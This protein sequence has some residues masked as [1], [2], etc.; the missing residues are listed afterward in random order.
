[1]ETPARREHPQ[2]APLEINRRRGLDLGPVGATAVVAGIAAIAVAAILAVI[3]PDVVERHLLD[4]EA[5]SIHGTVNK[6]ADSL[7][8]SEVSAEVDPDL[9]QT[10]V[11]RF[12][13]GR[14]IVRVKIWDP[15]GTIVFSDEERLIGSTYAMSNDL[16]A[17]F[18]GELISETPDLTRPENRYDTTFGELREY[19]IPV[20]SGPQGIEVV[21]EVYQ[22][23]D[24]LVNT[25]ADIRNAVRAALGIG[26]VMLLAALTAAA[27]AN[28]RAERRRQAR[29]QRLIGQLIEIREDERTRIIGALHDDIGQPLYRILFGLQAARGMVEEGSDVERELANLDGLVRDVDG[30]L[31]TELTALREEPG[32]EIDLELALAELVEITESETGLEI[33]FA[34]DVETDLPLPHRATL[35]RAAR[36]ALTN[37]DRHAHADHVIVR[38]VE[39]RDSTML[40]VIDNGAGSIGSPG[41]GLTT[42]M[43][44]LEAIGGGIDITN[45]KGG[46]T[47]FIAYVPLEH[48]VNR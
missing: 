26:A 2:R 35:Y 38:L 11:E 22:A 33:D 21:F 8:V 42:T 23:A 36:E 13:L 20:D 30:T 18:S 19:Y 1:M 14:E 16:V 24:R 29:S 47:R 25:V 43:D 6:I 40:E 48:T 41:L 9:L 31:R 17:A 15:S 32:V 5:A 4:T 34:S 37:V 28:A 10:L 27:I 7:Y 46:G 3:I 44:R 12:L 39:G 45:T